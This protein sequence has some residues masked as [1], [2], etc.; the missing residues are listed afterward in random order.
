MTRHASLFSFA[1][2]LAC[3]PG[4]IRSETTDEVGD[5]E[6]GP[7]PD[8]PPPFD[9][10]CGGADLMTDND[11]CGTCG[12]KCWDQIF[13]FN[14]DDWS[15]G[16]GCNDGECGGPVWS[17][18]K[19]PENGSTCRELL[20]PNAVCSS[21]CNAKTPGTTVLLF[22]SFNPFGGACFEL[23]SALPPQELALG[24]DDPIP[25]P[26]EG[27]AMC[28]GLLLDDPFGDP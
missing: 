4:S 13:P 28:C 27:T 24:C 5:E 16:G 18:C 19:W 12:H 2:L 7:E 11:N 22:D 23:I 3:S 25:Y 15:G 8:L 9:L 10:P 21:E 6:T 26:P 20:E 14:S 17:A 1:L